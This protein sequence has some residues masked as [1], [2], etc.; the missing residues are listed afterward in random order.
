MMYANTNRSSHKNLPLPS[1]TG[2]FTG[3]ITYYDPGGP[4]FG[5]CGVASYST[6]PICAVSHILYDA[7]SVSSNPNDNPLCGQMIRITRFDSTEGKNNSIDVKVVDRCVGCAADDLDLSES[8]FADLASVALG[9]VVA[10]W[11]WLN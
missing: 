3:D 1:N 2:V 8:M 4:G 7:A 10:S 9:R 11:A 5:A 6:D